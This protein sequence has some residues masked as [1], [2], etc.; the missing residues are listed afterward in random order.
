VGIAAVAG[1][2]QG[3][4]AAEFHFSGNN[5]WLGATIVG[6]DQSHRDNNDR[7]GAAVT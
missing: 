1:A 5:Q 6:Y 2:T 3:Y 4:G 7:R